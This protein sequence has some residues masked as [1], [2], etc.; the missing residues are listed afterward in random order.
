MNTQFLDQRTAQDRP[1]D[2]WPVHLVTRHELDAHVDALMSGSAG[3]DGRREV[4]VAHPK[5]VAPGR[6]L[7]PGVDVAFGALLPGESTVPRRHNASEVVMVLAGQVRA[8]VGDA[9]LTL[10]RRDT[11][12]I[13]SMLVT[14]LRNDG[15]EAATYVA[16]SN[17]PV[18]QKLEVYYL[19]LNPPSDADQATA[20][21]QAEQFSVNIS[22]AKEL[23]PGFEIGQD[24][25]WLLPYEH[26]VDPEFVE[27][28][29][30]KWAWDD[31]APHLGLLQNLGQGYTGR[32]LYCLYNPATGSRNGTTFSFFATISNAAGNLVGPVHRHNSAAINFILDGSG[33]SI[34]DGTKIT[35]EA[36]DIMLS[37]PGW[38]AH[39]HATGPDGAV[40]LT[41]QDHPFHIGSESLIW[42]EDLDGGPILSLGKQ[43]GFQTN[44]AQFAPVT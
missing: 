6:G 38:A 9:E 40:I 15:T 32:P 42:Q 25:G 12:N 7:A 19:E 39:G 3:A 27:S 34:V 17:R 36:G 21:Q 23:A 24:G 14:T 44:L 13:P 5:A 41:I 30:H 29:P 28:N 35:W 37:A 10:T 43:A 22:R 11:A 8:T 31:V 4:L 16:F 33:Y 26:L 1:N 20:L 18:L 2:M